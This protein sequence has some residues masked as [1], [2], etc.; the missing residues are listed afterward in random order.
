MLRSEIRDALGDPPGHNRRTV[1]FEKLNENI[2]VFLEYITSCRKAD[3]ALHRAA[4]YT[5]MRSSLGHLYRRYDLAQP[6]SVILDLKEAM[7]GTKNLC[8]QAQQHGEGNI[9]DGVRPLSWELYER[10]NQFFLMEGTEEGIFGVAFS[11]LCVNLA[12]RG[13]STA[14]VCTKHMRWTG[15]CLSIAFAHLKDAHDG[16]NAI[17]KLPRSIYC[18]LLNHSSCQLTALFDYI[19]RIESGHNQKT[20]RVISPWFSKKTRLSGL[21]IW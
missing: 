13:K 19:C 18:N 21:A 10:M 17:K 16:S 11:T 1:D 4:S 12:A 15:D 7:A 9:E 8:A 14:Q 6:P 3:G 5:G 2:S 20:T